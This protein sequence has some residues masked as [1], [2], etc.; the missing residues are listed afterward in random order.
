MKKHQAMP[1]PEVQQKMMEFFINRSV[2]L[3]MAEQQ[4]KGGVKK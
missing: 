4:N 2:P 1:P 3:I